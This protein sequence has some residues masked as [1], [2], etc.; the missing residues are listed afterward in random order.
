MTW[1]RI[2]NNNSESGQSSGSSQT[3][4]ANTG[5]IAKSNNRKEQA[6]DNNFYITKLHLSLS[7]IIRLVQRVAKWGERYL[8][9]RGEIKL[10]SHRS[11]LL[12]KYLLHQ[13]WKVKTERGE[14]DIPSVPTQLYEAEYAC[15]QPSCRDVDCLPVYGKHSLCMVAGKIYA[16]VGKVTVTPLQSYIT[17]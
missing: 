11:I 14:Q 10:S 12:D 4:S 8:K 2:G 16:V 7:F 6:G 15:S 3:R 13:R 9:I 1:I 17:T 5:S